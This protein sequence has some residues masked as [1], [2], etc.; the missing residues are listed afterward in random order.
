M[1][2]ALFDYLTDKGINDFKTWTEKLQKTQRA[3]L[4]VR[5]DML[6]HKGP[7]LFPQILTGTNTAGIQKLRVPG[8]I[9][10]RPMLC[11]GPINVKTEFTLLIGAI[12]KQGKL[13]PKKADQI[14]DDRKKDVSKDNTRR[15]KHERIS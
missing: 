11:K 8:K 12:E 6:E 5:L 9:Q 4:N 1:K 13:Q 14:A 7:E 10:L 2:Y 3:K 15:I